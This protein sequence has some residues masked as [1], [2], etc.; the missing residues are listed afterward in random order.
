MDNHIAVFIVDDHPIF[1][2]G[3]RQV[4]ESDPRLRMVGEA[5]D[6]VSALE[7]IRS[8]QPDV[9]VVDIELP[10]LH[11][12]DLARK[13]L[14][15][16]QPV[17]VLIL[18]M[19]KDERMV[20]AAL[21][22]GV[23]GYLIKENAATEVVSAIKAVASGETYICPSVSSYLLRRR[24]RADDLRSQKPGLD[25]LTHMERRVLKLIAENKT[26]RQIGQQLF[27]SI[28][29]VETHRTNICAKLNLHGSHPLLQFALDHKSDL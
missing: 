1:R 29:T 3:L 10:R 23:K 26:S 12:L 25:Q 8:L 11:G 15:M 16:R 4:I 13:L 9:A 19:H 24:G 27:V 5:S 22:A 2:Q 14:S 21:D 7:R 28:R 18:S 20:N 17:P 6:G